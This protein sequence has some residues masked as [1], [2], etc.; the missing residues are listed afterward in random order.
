M[1]MP[2]QYTELLK[3]V[4]SL[5]D[6]AP[7]PEPEIPD[8]LKAAR[9]RL[10]VGTNVKLPDVGTVGQGSKIPGSSKG[11]RNTTASSFWD[12]GHSG[13]GDT[14]APASGLKMSAH[15]IASP[16]LPIGTE[17]VIRRGNRNVRA[18]VG[19][20]GPGSPQHKEMLDL[21]VPLAAYLTGQNH[22][23]ARTSTMHKMQ[24]QVV[25]WGTGATLYKN[26]SQAQRY[27]SLYGNLRKTTAQQAYRDTRGGL[28]NIDYRWESAND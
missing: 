12:T 23:K 28:R 13:F 6:S 11:W 10:G 14:G 16:W 17:V 9:K 7:M 19:D 26:S 24:F 27:R 1:T 2:N 4:T 21:S 18:F 8:Y 25:S 3:K 15:M 20:L 5:S 22:Q